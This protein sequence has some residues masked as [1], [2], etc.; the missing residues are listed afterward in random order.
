MVYATENFPKGAAAPEWQIVSRRAEGPD[1]IWS[2]PKVQVTWA[3]EPYLYGGLHP[4][5][6]HQRLRRVHLMVGTWQRDRHE[7]TT[8][9]QGVPVRRDPLTTP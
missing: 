1:R 5:L 9:Y 8:A 7:T 4:P 2:E 3:Q 6:L